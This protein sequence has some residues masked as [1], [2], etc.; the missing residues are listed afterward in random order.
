[1]SCIVVVFFGRNDNNNNKKKNSRV[2]NKKRAWKN[3]QFSCQFVT[4]IFNRFSLSHS[5]SHLFSN[6]LLNV[7]FLGVNNNKHHAQILWLS[8]FVQ[9]EEKKIS[10][11]NFIFLSTYAY[12]YVEHFGFRFL[13][14]FFLFIMMM[15][16]MRK[17]K[18]FFS[19]K[20]SAHYN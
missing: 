19:K 7:L 11:P 3:F 1:M 9:R 5:H 17:K 16:S 20:N 12:I 8:V 4:S 2:N 18:F 13:I 6:V 14:F 15:M 10:K